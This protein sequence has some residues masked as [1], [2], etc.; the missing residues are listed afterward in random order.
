MN[1]TNDTYINI[2]SNNQQIMMILT[3]LIITSLN[4]LVSNLLNRESLINFRLLEKLFRKCMF[5]KKIKSQI[6]INATKSTNWGE[7][8][9]AFPIAYKAIIYILLKNN[10]QIKKM[11][12][13]T[14]YYLRR[15]NEHSFYIDSDNECEEYDIEENIRVKFAKSYED[16]GREKPQIV[17]LIISIY[18]YKYDLKFLSTKMKKWISEYKDENEIYKDDGKKYYFSLKDSSAKITPIK[19]D[20]NGDEKNK[21]K[22]SDD[23]AEMI[24]N[25]AEMTS[26]KTFS[27]TFFT[28]KDILLKRIKY[29]MENEE[30]YNKRGIPYNIGILMHG[31]PGCGKTSSIKAISNL[32]NRHIIEVNLKKIKT[33]GEFENIFYNNKLNDLYIPHKKKMIVLEDIDCMMGIIQSREKNSD[34]NNKDDEFDIMNKTD[35]DVAKFIF[36][37]EKMLSIEQKKTKSMYSPTDELTLSCILN[38]IDGVLENYGRIIVI[39]TNYPEKI[40]SALIRPGR[41]DLKINFTK[42]TNKMISEIINNFYEDEKLTEDKIFPEY[43]YTPAEVLEICA[44]HYDNPAKALSIISG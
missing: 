28:D 43:K 40:D 37:Q 16:A 8:T 15:N 22:N 34:E 2:I 36:L 32:T 18:S 26:H 38:T 33:C 25:M 3:T 44:L 14:D 7:P 29:F 41:V 17:N 35:N 6:D 21:N 5:W 27:N 30:L 39:T 20:T 42:C 11:T 24:W 9:F 10:I 1:S 19:N 4:T 12:Q 13:P 23:N 31:S